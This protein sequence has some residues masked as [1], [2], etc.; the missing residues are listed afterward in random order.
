LDRVLRSIVRKLVRECEAIARAGKV[1]PDPNPIY[2]ADPI[3]SGA[4][5]QYESHK[6]PREISLRQNRDISR[7][8]Y[9]RR[10]PSLLLI[11]LKDG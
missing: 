9:G 10:A 1:L 4:R 5:E 2:L 11:L 6:T 7:I 8:L 3:G